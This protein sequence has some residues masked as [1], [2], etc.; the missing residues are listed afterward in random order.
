MTQFKFN[1]GTHC[2]AFFVTPHGY[3]HAARASCVMEAM[4][5]INPSI[6]FE[7]F[8]KVP[9][10][11]FKQSIS[12][13][14]GYHSLLTDI[15]IVQKSPLSEDLPETIRS[16]DRFLPFDNIVVKSISG[17]LKQMR[18][19]MVISDIAPL[20]IAVAKEAGIPSVL[21]E[22]FTW[23]WIYKEYS[24][25]ECGFDKHIKYLK[26][27]F[28]QADY[29]IQTEPICKL[30]VNSDFTSGPI[31]R[32]VRLPSKEV[33]LKLGVRP[34]SK[35]ILITMGGISEEFT[36]LNKLMNLKDINFIIPG[37]FEKQTVSEN[38]I[39]LPKQSEFFHPDLVNASD[40]VICKA[41]YSTVAEVYC[42]GVPSGYVIRDRFRESE[43]IDDYVG[44]NMKGIPITETE[45]NDHTWISKIE[46]LLTIPRME[47]NGPTGADET[48]GFICELESKW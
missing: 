44:K 4:L 48:A 16:L 32:K 24:T 34:D 23:D 40:V 6:R 38:L 30:A 27:C 25:I 13:P 36:F 8:T 39:L 11:F 12:R 41:G 46:E 43:V 37:D 42:S 45:Y 26:S 29:H 22:N 14:F 18:C 15:G 2:I 21:I 28:A 19:E 9:E 10:W 20:G 17:I 7:I 47:R 35:L 3:G 1:Q 33:R 31:S 5:E